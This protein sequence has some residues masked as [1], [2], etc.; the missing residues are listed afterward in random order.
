MISDQTGVD[1]LIRINGT[2]NGSAGKVDFS[3]YTRSDSDG[4]FGFDQLPEG[5][6]HL[7]RMIQIDEQTEMAPISQII[8]VQS[9]QTTQTQLGGLGRPMIGRVVWE[10]SKTTYPINYGLFS[11]LSQSNQDHGNTYQFMVNDDGTFRI[12]DVL[13]GTYTLAGTMIKPNSQNNYDSKNRIIRG[14]KVI[15]VT[16]PSNDPGD[17]FTPM[18][19]K[20]DTLT[21][22]KMSPRVGDLAMD[23]DVPLLTPED[24]TQPL[25]TTDA[26]RFK[27]SD[28]KGKVVLVQFWATWCGS[29]VREMPSLQQV[30]EKY[31]SN[32]HFEMISLALNGSPDDPTE[33]A[34]NKNLEWKHGFIGPW[35]SDTP[36]AGDYGV[37]SIPRI[38]LIGTDGSIQGSLL[39]GHAILKT[40][41]QVMTKNQFAPAQD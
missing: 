9:D 28:H 23:F 16:L 32:K 3:A 6:H 5:Q 36:V 24:P 29:C 38:F 22:I 15:T 17:D 31:G 30:W 39:R 12:E 27:L 2:I 20:T 26:T 41:D 7:K 34:K 4:V 10:Y 1:Q 18:K 21:I 37:K 40:V 33:Y 19:P 14:D 11:L 13:P 35:D 8:R 25:N